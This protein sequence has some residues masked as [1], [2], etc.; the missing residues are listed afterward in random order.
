MPLCSHP[1]YT[2]LYA[3]FWSFRNFRPQFRENCVTIERE[4]DLSS[5]FERAITSEK[6]WK[7]HKSRLIINH[8]TC[9]NYVPHAQTDQA[10]QKKQYGIFSH[11]QPA[12]VV[13][14]PQTF[15]GDRGRRDSSKKC[16]PFFD[17]THNSY[18][19]RKCWILASDALTKFNTGRLP[20]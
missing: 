19:G 17:P 4:R 3:D 18:T 8:D 6:G 2:N 10:W 11:L 5:A 16:Q 14:S 1:V 20:W 15:H 13:W 7:Q 9:S 12:R